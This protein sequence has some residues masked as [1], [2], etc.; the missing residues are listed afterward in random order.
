[1][2]SHIMVFLQKFFKWRLSLKEGYLYV[3]GFLQIVLM[4]SFKDEKSNESEESNFLFFTLLLS[5]LTLT[6]FSVMTRKWHISPFGFISFCLKHLS[7]L[8][9]FL[10]CLRIYLNLNH[11]C[12]V[13]YHQ[14]SWL[15]YSLFLENISQMFMLK[16]RGPNTDPSR[17]S[18]F[19]SA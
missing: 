18:D 4:W 14:H 17:T 8:Y 15:L 13:C 12:E 2:N 7:R 3:W 9:S 11:M 1:M 10:T 19:V 16:R 6:D 5:I